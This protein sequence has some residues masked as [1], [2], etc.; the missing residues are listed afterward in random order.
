MTD[1][2]TMAR[3][4]DASRLNNRAQQLCIKTTDVRNVNETFAVSCC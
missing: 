3:N 2:Y 1:L 4:I